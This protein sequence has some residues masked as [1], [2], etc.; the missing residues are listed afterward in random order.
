MLSRFGDDMRPVKLKKVVLGYHY[1]PQIST[2]FKFDIMLNYK[3][4]GVIL[5]HAEGKP[6][7]VI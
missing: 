7:L 1:N 3:L 4:Q 5:Q 6:T 2:P